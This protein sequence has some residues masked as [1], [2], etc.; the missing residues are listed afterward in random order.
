MEVGKQSHDILCTWWLSWLA[1]ERP[2]LVLSPD[3]TY[4][5]GSGDIWADYF[6]ERNFSPPNHIAEKTICSAP[7][8]T[9]GYFSKVTRHFFGV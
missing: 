5:R 4:E 7:P 6:L 9:L 8:E 3:A 2:W 1:V